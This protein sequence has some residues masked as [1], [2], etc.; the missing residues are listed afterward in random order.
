MNY[1][2]KK[3]VAEDTRVLPLKP[4]DQAAF[5]LWK[6]SASEAQRRWTGDSGFSAREGTLCAVPGADGGLSCWLLGTGDQD[7][8]YQLATAA[9]GLPQGAYRLDCDWPKAERAQAALG[10]GLAGYRFDRYKADERQSPVLLL[11]DSHVL[12]FQAGGNLHARGAGLAD[13]LALEL[14]FAVDVRELTDEGVPGGVGKRRC[15]AAEM[16]VSCDALV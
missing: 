13:Q 7:S 8:L 15:R 5:E 2:S 12:V 4:L 3:E 14:G 10:W 11:G 9:T 6:S 1:L 16:A